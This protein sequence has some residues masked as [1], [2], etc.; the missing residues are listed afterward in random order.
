MSDN[1]EIPFESDLLYYPV[2]DHYF[3]SKQ[4]V[5]PSSCEAGTAG[6]LLAEFMI[7]CLISESKVPSQRCKRNG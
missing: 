5:V 3:V 4:A 7:I 6:C 1:I 2:L